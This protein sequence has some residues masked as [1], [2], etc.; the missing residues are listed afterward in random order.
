MA[1][2]IEPTTAFGA[3]AI[4]KSDTTVFTRMPSALYV[5][6]GGDVTV[7]MASGETVLFPDVPEGSILPIK[8]DQVRS[9]NTDAEGFVGLTY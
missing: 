6:S 2:P 4:T 8:I 1:N 5:G 9:S 7:R 3:F